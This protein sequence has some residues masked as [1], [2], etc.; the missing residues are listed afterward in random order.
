MKVDMGTVWDRTTEFLSDNFGAIVPVFAGALW[1][2]QMLSSLLG[3]AV[4]QSG[5]MSLPLQA[6]VLLLAL[7]GIWGQLA[8]V[9]HALN[10]D[11]GA[12]AART[13]ATRS[14]GYALLISLVV[15]LAMF[16]LLL[17]AIIALVAGGLDMAALAKGDARS[18]FGMVGPGT[19]TFVALYCLVWFVV[20]IWIGVRVA[21]ANSVL[22]A[23]RAGLGA[24]ARSFALTRGI[25][26]KM[27]GVYLLFF[28]VLAVAS[29]A[30]TSVFGF[31][32]AL[33][34]PNGG[35]WGASAIIVAMLS[36]LVGAIGT[37]IIAA[38]S[39]KLYRAVTAGAASPA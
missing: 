18:A 27:V 5:G 34:L 22:I 11:A 3:N 31:I 20:A 38:F 19:G 16:A 21:L 26:W 32:F 6:I 29:S 17:P 1:L 28:I 25:V 10:P 37:L 7:I 8:I 2:P 33:V 12:P 35:P 23:E 36:G 4:A 14:F 13:A 24:I 9:A 30:V 15:G 39:A